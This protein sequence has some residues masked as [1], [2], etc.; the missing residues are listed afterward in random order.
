MYDTEMPSD[1]EKIIESV[2]DLK[3]KLLCSEARRISRIMD[4]CI[5]QVLTMATLPMILPKLSKFTDKD[6]INELQKHKQICEKLEK[7][8][9]DGEQEKPER[10]GKK[11]KNNL[12]RDIKNSS[13]DL[14]RFLRSCPE[15]I[16]ALKSVPGVEIGEHELNLVVELKGFHSHML[17]KLLTSPC[18]EKH[19]PFHKIGPTHL[20]KILHDLEEMSLEEAEVAAAMK[21]VNAKIAQKNIEIE[22]LQEVT[23]LTSFAAENEQLPV[24]PSLTL[25][26]RIDQLKIQVSIS[27]RENTESLA[28]LN[29]EDEG[30]EKIFDDLCQTHYSDVDEPQTDLESI[31][32]DPEKEEEKKL[33][34]DNLQQELLKV[35]EDEKDLL[36]NES[37]RKQAGLKQKIN[38][39][40]NELNKLQKENLDAE[41][42]LQG[43]NKKLEKVK[44]NM[45]KTYENENKQ[46]QEELDLEELETQKEEDKLKALQEAYAVLKEE[47]DQIQERL[48]EEQRQRELLQTKIKA[49][50]FAQAW[51][52]GYCTRKA[53]KEQAEKGKAGGKKGKKGKDK[54]GKGKGKG[55]K[56]K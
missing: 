17:N 14:L 18:H 29:K 53:L 2:D 32:E 7:K 55:K 56:K 47:Y 22:N 51:W 45:Q 5:R 10:T 16:V 36:Y 54:K 26:E 52:R 46:R 8:I 13:R 11:G 28:V 40:E 3:K 31:E 19:L 21:K 15:A 39:M 43:R 35:L 33:A 50:T 30:V 6:L 9:E 34:Q 20:D 1:V 49:A 44:E 41:I 27:K 4:N 38:Q 24:N 42:K 48:A 37:L 23:Q 25:Q 12:E